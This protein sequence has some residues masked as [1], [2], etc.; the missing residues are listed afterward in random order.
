MVDTWLM[1][2]YG[3]PEMGIPQKMD[4]LQR[5]IHLQMDEIPRGTPIFTD[6]P[7]AFGC[8]TVLNK[9]RATSTM[10]RMRDLCHV[11]SW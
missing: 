1:M 4:V 2:V 8:N 10:R 9:N 6:P 11:Y 5:K 7:Y 3:F